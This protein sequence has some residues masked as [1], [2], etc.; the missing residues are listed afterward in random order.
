MTG[1]KVLLLGK[2]QSHMDGCNA[3]L[4]DSCPL[5]SDLTHSWNRLLRC[6]LYWL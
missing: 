5:K 1:F 4:L 2:G 3:M 6:R